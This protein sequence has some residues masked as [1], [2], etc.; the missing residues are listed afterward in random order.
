MDDLELTL[1]N[2]ER[3]ADVF[4]RLEEMSPEW[5]DD[6]VESNWDLVTMVVLMR[7]AEEFGAT[8]FVNA[9]KRALIS[10][11]RGIENS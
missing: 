7:E 4:P 11:Y 9:V 1:D 2:I 3:M 8:N 6:L 5:L 10:K